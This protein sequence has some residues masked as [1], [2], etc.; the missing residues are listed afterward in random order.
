MIDKYAYSNARIRGMKTFLLKSNDLE[1][2]GGAKSLKEFVALLDQTP[3]KEVSSGLGEITLPGIDRSLMTN[4]MGTVN[5]IIDI[6][7]CKSLL[8]SISKKY[9]IGCVKIILNAKASNISMDKIRDK[10]FIETELLAKLMETGKL[11]DRVNLLMEKYEGLDEFIDKES[12]EFPSNAVIGLDRYYF[13]MLNG[14]IDKLH[15][16]NHKI[17]LMLIGMEIDSKNIMMILRGI[18]HGYETKD[19]LIPSHSHC[20]ENCIGAEEVADVVSKLSK[21]VYGPILTK[22]MPSYM[23][24]NSLLPFELALKKNVID[25]HIKAMEGYPLQLGTVLGFLKLKE[26]EIENLRIICIGI[27]NNMQRNEI[28]ELLMI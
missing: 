20:V 23:K 5:K 3:Y 18:S 12:E 24:T 21:T 15:L 26:N 22:A 10:I 19:L 28:K 27:E 11:E 4:L 14:E 25:K 7:P 17:A 9:E 8:E 16:R 2:L 1:R 13:A 6:S